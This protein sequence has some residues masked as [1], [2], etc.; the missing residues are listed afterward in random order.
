VHEFIFEFEMRIDNNAFPKR[1][2]HLREDDICIEIELPHELK[3][4]GLQGVIFKY[5]GQVEWDQ[6]QWQRKYHPGCC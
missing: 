1:K 4:W 3:E 2:D 6:Y 5:I